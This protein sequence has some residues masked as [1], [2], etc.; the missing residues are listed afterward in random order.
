MTSKQHVER[1]KQVLSELSAL[2][3]L[4]LEMHFERFEQK[5][6]TREQ[7]RSNELRRRQIEQR[8]VRAVQ[9]LEELR[10]KEAPGEGEEVCRELG[11]CDRTPRECRM[12]GK[13]FD[14]WPYGSRSTIECNDC[15]E[16]SER[17]IAQLPPLTNA[18]NEFFRRDIKLPG[19]KDRSL[20]EI[21]TELREARAARL[22]KDKK[23]KLTDE[24]QDDLLKEL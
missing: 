21:I 22:T 23:P 18:V 10:S 11:L 4:L 15:R 19:E 3:P 5:R 13:Q 9:A 14:P 12:C 17:A 24:E 7:M 6:Q 20:N 1:V 8:V 2:D 16:Q